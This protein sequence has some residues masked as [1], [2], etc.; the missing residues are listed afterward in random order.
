MGDALATGEI[1]RAVLD[2][3]YLSRASRSYVV[4]AAARHDV[5][6]RCVW[7][8]TPPAE[9]QVNL[10]HRLLDHFGR[11]PAP[12]EIG[13]RAR[14]PG[15]ML[16]TSQM[17]AV[18]ELEPPVRRRGVRRGAAAP[19]PAD[20]GARRRPRR[21]LIAASALDAEGWD[22][23]LDGPRGARAGVRLAARRLGERPGP[24]RRAGVRRA[25]GAA[26]L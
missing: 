3:T 7:V 26:G 5:P 16:P 12:E 15:L 25:P 8:D 19:I 1:T 4:E 11:L 9:A 23:P 17:R 24:A 14:A 13:R 2:N 10:V 22:A 6:V 21:V 20:V 18:R